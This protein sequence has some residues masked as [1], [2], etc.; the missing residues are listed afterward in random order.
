MLSETK[1]DSSFPQVQFYIEEYSK[2][3]NTLHDLSDPFAVLKKTKMYNVNTN[4]IFYIIFG[5]I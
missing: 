4:V 1:L 3:Q 2:G 5:F